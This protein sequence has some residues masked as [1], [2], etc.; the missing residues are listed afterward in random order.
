MAGMEEMLGSIMKNPQA[1]QQIFSL[2]QSLGLPQ[3]QAQ[4]SEP[5]PAQSQAPPPA[6]A[7]LPAQSQAPSGQ[8]DLDGMFRT[9]LSLASQSGGND[10]Q[11]L[12]FEALK[13]FL[14]PDRAKQLDRAMQVA[15][16]SQMAGSAMKRL[17][18]A[19]HGTGGGNHV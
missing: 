18:G 4:A 3:N 8:P 10:R 17:G 9:I 2:A 5:T 11:V 6:P 13:P 14:R 12:L 7:P 15:Q 16:I 1:M 19:S